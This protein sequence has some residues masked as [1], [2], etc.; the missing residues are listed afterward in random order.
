MNRRI[1]CHRPNSDIKGAKSCLYLASS[2]PKC[3]NIL[4]KELHIQIADIRD[5]LLNKGSKKC[6]I[7]SPI[8]LIKVKDNLDYYL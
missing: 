1:C 4:A 3:N 8:S 7:N 2:L 5:G 6:S